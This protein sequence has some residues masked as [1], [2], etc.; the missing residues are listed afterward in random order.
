MIEARAAEV[1]WKYIRQ[2]SPLRL[3]IS[4]EEFVL[5]YEN[6]LIECYRTAQVEDFSVLNVA[7]ESAA[8]L[9]NL[10]TAEV[11]EV[12][13]LLWTEYEKCCEEL[14]RNLMEIANNQLPRTLAARYRS[15]LKD[16][17]ISYG[18]ELMRT[19]LASLRTIMERMLEVLTTGEDDSF[20]TIE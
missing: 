9:P 16:K 5:K 13:F 2:D 6:E 18:H 19:S 20:L 3:E 12:D 10:E 7:Y 14:L 1:I 11:S 4:A 15:A 17:F 8:V